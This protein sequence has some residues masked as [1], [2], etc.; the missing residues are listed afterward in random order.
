MP[1]ARIWTGVARLALGLVQGLALYGLNEGRG[2]IAPEWL[3]ALYLVVL[4][5]PLI[6]IGGLGAL[7]RITL[8]LWA[9][10]AAVLLAGLGWYDVVRL[11]NSEHQAFSPSV[12]LA[13]AAL[14]FVSH[15]L[16]AGADEA[17]RWIAPYERYF[18]LGWR[19]G[20]QLALA[21]MFTGAFWLVLWLG[22][23]LFELIN[24]KFLRQLMD[25]TWFSIPATTSMFAAAIHVTALQSGL[26]R[27]FRALG[28]MLLSWLAPVMSVLVGVF[29]LMLPFTGL[30]PLWDTR[31]ATSIMLGACVALVVLINATYQD[32]GQEALPGWLRRWAVRVAAVLLTPLAV[33][34]AYALYLRIDQYGLTPE[35]IY[36]MAVLTIGI[37]YAAS[38][39]AGAFW[40]RWMRPLEVGNIAAAFAIVV[41]C[42]AIFSPVADPARLSVD[43][44]MRRF[45]AGQVSA[46]ELD[47]RFL[48]FQGGRYGRDALE[49]LRR[50]TDPVL[51]K[52]AVEALAAENQYDRVFV[53]Q[54]PPHVMDIKM[55]PDDVTLPESFL[56]ASNLGGAIDSCRYSEDRCDAYLLDMNNDGEKDVVLATS[57]VVSV[58][59]IGDDGAW[60]WVANSYHVATR[61]VQAGDV[62]AAP[63]QLNDLMIGGRRY[64]LTPVEHGRVITAR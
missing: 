61:A 31:A 55:H 51:A 56:S 40:K 21:G 38:Y 3:A 47:V 11:T 20:A 46:A 1:W 39:L 4:F 41:M 29:L 59:D 8:V 24:L 50:A 17:R 45:A 64:A 30:Q 23:A 60:R 13:A 28:L 43:D 2:H 63:A 62:R 27:G 12:F 53:E 48:R 14:V 33:L 15:H 22:A 49:Q 54:A 6:V 9:T 5:V 10:A 57:H 52:R 19:H 25:Q 35:R 58:Y 7:R 44:Q 37:S 34:A 16:V 26:V 32:G 36:A 18:D 42:L